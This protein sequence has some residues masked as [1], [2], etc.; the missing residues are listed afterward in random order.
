MHGSLR[1]FYTIS[2]PL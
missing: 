1:N 2:R